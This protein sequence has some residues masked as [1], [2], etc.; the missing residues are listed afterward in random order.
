MIDLHSHI[1]PSL[2][3]GAKD[4]SDSLEMAKMAVKNGTKIIA[5]TPHSYYLDRYHYG[6]EPEAA[7]EAFEILKLVLEEENIPLTLVTG[8]EIFGDRDTAE[9]LTKKRLLTLNYTRSPLIEFDFDVE[10]DFIWDVMQDV[11]S[12]GFTPVLAHPERYKCLYYNTSF[13]YDLYEANVALQVNKGSIMG[14]FGRRVEET[15]HRILRHRLA[16]LVASDAHNIYSRTTDMLEL[17]DMLDEMYGDGCSDLLLNVN[18][19]RILDG[20]EVIW[21]EPIEL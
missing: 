1:L 10:E 3:D 7:L 14:H 13:A 5:G 17:A 4:L 8:M 6:K 19:K 18:P 16:A 21:A 2:D 12:A 9:K 20:K 15:A 11:K